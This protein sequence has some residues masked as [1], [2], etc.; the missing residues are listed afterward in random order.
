MRDKFIPIIKIIMAYD[1]EEQEQLATLKAWW[2][3]YGNM[4]TW[5]VTAVLVA[6]AAW[7]GWKYYQRDQSS[8]GVMLYEEIVKA[9]ESKDQ[10]KLARATED[11]KARFSGTPYAQMGLLLAAKASFEAN[12]VK[13]AKADLQWIVDH[14]HTDEFKAIARIRLA[15]LLLDEKAY[16]EGLKLLSAEFPEQFAALVADRRGDLLFAQ[17]KLDDARKEFKTALE[18][19]EIKNPARQL[20]QLKLDALGW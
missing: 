1:H 6:F 10:A 12:D 4:V 7:S 15:G 16:D 18:K 14:G 9:A 13:S 3:Q 19:T 11:I 2:N 17:K 5:F 20:I 8:K